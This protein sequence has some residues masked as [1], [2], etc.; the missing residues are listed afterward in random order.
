VL[1]AACSSNDKNAK[2]STTTVAPGAKTFQLA[3]RLDTRQ[4]VTPANRPWAA[5]GVVARAAGTF[6]GTL[7]SSTR[8]L[9]WTLTYVRLG[10]PRLVIADVHLGRPG[11]FGAVIVRL[12]GPCGSR[13]DRGNLTLSPEQADQIVA[14]TGSWVTVITDAYRDGVIRGQ[15][16]V[17]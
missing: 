5:P 16:K 8:E 13:A 17:R 12:C 10:Q 1:V 4:V 11:R 9:R 15:I 6:S 14:P 7:N 3:A 2:P